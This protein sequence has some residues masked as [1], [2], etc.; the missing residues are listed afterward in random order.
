MGRGT[1]DELAAHAVAYLNSDTNGRGYLGIEGSHSLE[2]FINGVAKDVEDPESER[3]L[4]EAQSGGDPIVI[5]EATPRRAQRDDL[6]IGALGSGSDFTPFLQHLGIASLNLGYGGEDDGGIYHSIYDDFYWYT[7]FSD[8]AFVYGRALAQA[9][10]TTVM[11][12]ADA[13]VLPFVF[14]NLAATTA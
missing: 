6:R 10:G 9:A 13:D 8:T 7:H 11:R 3:Q 4:V 12:L 5:A 14:T 1:R 2:K